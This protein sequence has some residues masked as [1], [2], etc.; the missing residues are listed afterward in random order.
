MPRFRRLPRVST[1]A[2][3]IERAVDDE[4]R[5]H[6]QMRVEELMREGKSNA[7]ARAQA[8]REYGDVSA[9]LTELTGIDRRAA[10][11]SDWREFA[12]S[13]I[14]DARISA[15]GLRARPGFALTVLLTLALGIGANA[16]I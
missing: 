7:S 10:R 8:E 2:R 6:L 15:R 14:Q 13:W 11:K 1:S 5:F 3:A 4:M 9:A 12:A 16:A